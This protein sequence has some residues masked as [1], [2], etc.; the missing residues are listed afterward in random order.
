MSNIKDKVV[1]ARESI[2]VLDADRG[3]PLVTRSNP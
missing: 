2:L 1:I 3:N